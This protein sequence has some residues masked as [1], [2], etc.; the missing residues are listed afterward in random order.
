LVEREEGDRSSFRNDW[1][2][3][4]SSLPGGETECPAIEV[5]KNGAK[6]RKSR[7]KKKEKRC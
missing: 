1:K 2:D 7:P 4:L 3:F 5:T 6:Y